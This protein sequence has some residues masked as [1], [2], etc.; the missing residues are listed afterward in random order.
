MLDVQEPKNNS[1]QRSSFE[2]LFYALHCLSKLKI[3]D[4]Y[5]IRLCCNAK[6]RKKKIKMRMHFKIQINSNLIIIKKNLSFVVLLL[7]KLNY[8]EPSYLFTIS[9]IFNNGIIFP[10]E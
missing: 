8:A 2:T 7:K 9:K 6:R 10:L 3:S 4:K 5:K 1:K